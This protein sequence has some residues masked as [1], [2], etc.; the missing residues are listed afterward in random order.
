MQHAGS[1]RIELLPSGMRQ[2]LC[3]PEVAQA[4]KQAANRLAAA[5]GDGFEVS[6][7]W[8]A[9]FGGGRAAYSVRA[10][11]YAARKA[12]AEDKVLTRA[13]FACRA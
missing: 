2:L 5:A 9:G 10:A 12:E 11:T 1:V 6:E 8:R 3:S 7:E 4:C 13:V